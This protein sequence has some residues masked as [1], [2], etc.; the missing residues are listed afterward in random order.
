MKFDIIVADPPWAYGDKLK[1]DKVKRGAASQYNTMEIDEICS[2][3]VNNLRN[4]SHSVL[5]L[6]SISSMLPESLKVM[7]SWGFKQKQILVWNKVK[8][9]PLESL[10]KLLIKENKKSPLTKEKI[11]ELCNNFDLS[12]TLSFGM[13]RLTRACHEICLVGIS[14]NAY[15]MLKQISEKRIFWTKL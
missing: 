5:F 15:S 6:W 2:I 14:G 4:P 8:K 10:Q 7:S 9:E 13:G 3:D 1:M 11:S 12:N